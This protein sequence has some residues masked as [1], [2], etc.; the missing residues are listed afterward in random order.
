MEK[1]IE[2]SHNE[3][4]LH[5]EKF[6]SPVAFDPENISQRKATININNKNYNYDGKESILEF[7]EQEDVEIPFACRVGVCGSCKCKLISGEVDE[8]TDSGLTNKE[9]KAGY[10]LT[11]VSRP[12]SDLKLELL[13]D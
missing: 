7:F 12:D 5:S 4:Y 11:C 9:K 1:L 10:I 3:N 13:K 6:A 2:G 8:I